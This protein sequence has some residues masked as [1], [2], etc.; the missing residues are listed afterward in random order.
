[1][2]SASLL[3]DHVPK[4]TVNAAKATKAPDREKLFMTDKTPLLGGRGSCGKG[5]VAGRRAMP[6]RLWIKYPPPDEAVVDPENA[7]TPPPSKTP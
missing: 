3:A 6:S 7:P 2:I 5:I 4:Q 1:M